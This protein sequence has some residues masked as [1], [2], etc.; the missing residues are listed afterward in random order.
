MTLITSGH[1]VEEKGHLRKLWDIKTK[2]TDGGARGFTYFWISLWKI[3]LFLG[4]M[5]LIAPVTNIVPY[6]TALFSN[7]VESFNT[8]EYNR[9]QYWRWIY[10]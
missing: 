1:F 3:T 7:F 10:R 9:E 6:Y 5:M 8:I 2:L 4:C